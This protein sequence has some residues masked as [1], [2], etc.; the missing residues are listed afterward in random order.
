M[1]KKRDFCTHLF[2]S[3]KTSCFVG[4]GDRAKNMLVSFRAMCTGKCGTNC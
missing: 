4:S 2:T 3:T 1:P